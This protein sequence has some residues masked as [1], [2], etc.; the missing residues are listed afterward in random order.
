MITH[1]SSRLPIYVDVLIV[2][3]KLTVQG[4]KAVKAICNA[5]SGVLKRHYCECEGLQKITIVEV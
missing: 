2:R 4:R 1:I 5:K 3:L